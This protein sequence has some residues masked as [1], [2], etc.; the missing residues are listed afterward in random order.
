MKPKILCKILESYCNKELHINKTYFFG[1]VYITT[2]ELNIDKTIQAI[3]NK[4]SGDEN[5]KSLIKCHIGVSGWFNFD[6]VCVNKSTDIIV[7]F[8][9]NPQVADFLKKTYE[10]II[11][12]STRELFVSSICKWFDQDESHNIMFYPNIKYADFLNPK[13]ET[14]AELTRKTSWLSNAKNYDYIRSLC[15]NQHV[16]I[17][18][19]DICNNNIFKKIQS[20]FN[21]NSVY[22]DT[23]YLSNISQY[24]MKEDNNKQDEFKTSIKSL[25]YNNDNISVIYCH[26]DNIRLSKLGN[27]IKSINQWIA[28]KIDKNNTF[29][30]SIVKLSEF[31]VAHLDNSIGDYPEQTVN[32]SKVI[33]ENLNMLI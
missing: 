4:N 20:L 30:S 1:G 7:L 28:P 21:E 3:K 2:N 17:L 13:E 18:T 19:F 32:T 22:I 33:L 10:L 5:Y 25:L 29:I 16:S 6:V 27:N 8:D 26:C 14:K 9:I 31:C 15:I 11:L 23:L 24:I 12:N